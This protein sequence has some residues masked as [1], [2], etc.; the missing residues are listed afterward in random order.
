MKNQQHSSLYIG[1]MSGTS[2][3]GVDA[4][5]CEMSEAQVFKC[6]DH[7][8]LSFSSTLRNDLLSLQ[9]PGENE[10]HRSA[11]LANQLAHLYAEVTHAL[12]NQTKTLA[13]AVVAIGCHGQ[14]IRHQPALGYTL[15]IGNMAL[16]AELTGI[17][18]VSDFRSRDI[19]AGG[20]GAPLVPAFHQ[21]V[22]GSL[23]HIN[24]IV[25][26]GGM[27]NL[28]YL[29]PNEPVIGFDCG[30]GNV[31]LDA[32]INS[33]QKLAYDANGAWASSGTLQ[34]DLL[35]LFL[36]HP[37]FTASPP[38]SCGREQFDLNWLKTELGRSGHHLNAADVQ[39]TLLALTAQSIAQAVNRHCPN[40]ETLLAC[41]GGTQNVALMMALQNALPNIQVSTT[42]DMGLPADWV[43]AAAFAWLAYR[44]TTNQAGNL[45]A[46]TGASAPRVL[47]CC[48]KP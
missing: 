40:T 30:P 35:S 25:N 14:T 39:A 36:Q 33:N 43:E 19:A 6:I 29:N 48:H 18:V 42:A 22:F 21:A 20:Q 2:M 7:A 13:Q 17:A 37:F 15:Q 47:G 28:T 44:Y 45:P 23:K 12:L 11:L 41:G 9:Y 38:K 27:A 31:L 4:V 32:W 1:L 3:D 8:H 10:L 5:L 24:T 34:P 26:I 46:V 16:L